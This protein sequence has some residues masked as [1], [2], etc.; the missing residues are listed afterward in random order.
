[1]GDEPQPPVQIFKPLPG[2]KPPGPLTLGE[3]AVENWKLFK[4]KW[5]IYET[6]IKLSTYDRE[7]QVASL[8]NSLGDEALRAYN[9]FDFDTQENVRT[10]AEITAKFDTFI[11]GDVNETYER[12]KFNSTIQREGET[13]ETF[14]SN[15]RC[16]IKTCNYCA[17]C[18]PSILRDRIVLGI[19]E[20]ST[21]QMLLR[22]RDLA[23]DKCIDICKITEDAKAQFDAYKPDPE[24]VNAVSRGRKSKSKPKQRTE[25]RDQTKSKQQGQKNKIAECKFCGKTHEMKKSSCPAWG[26][27]CSNCG[28]KNHYAAKCTNRSDKVNAV[29]EISDSE[30]EDWVCTVTDESVTHKPVRCRMIV[31]NL[32]VVFLVDSGASINIIPK[33]WLTDPSR[34]TPPERQLL[35]WNKTPLT[36]IGSYQATVLN[37]KTRATYSVKFTVVSEDFMPLIG[38]ETALKMELIDVNEHNMEMVA[39]VS[40]TEVLFDDKYRVLWEE[41]LGTFEGEVHL[42]VDESVTPVIMPAKRIP[43]SLKEK[44]HEEL[45]RMQELG[46]IAQVDEPTPWVNQIAITQ[47]KSGAIRVCLDPQQLNRALQREHFMLPVLEDTLHEL[48]T[49][50]VFS[51]FDL[52]SGYWHVGLDHESSLLTTFQ[53][54]FGRYRWLRLPFGLSVSSEIFQKKLLENLQ[55]LSGIACIA[56]DIMVH[57]SDNKTHDTALEALMER[58]L[59]KQIRLNKDK[60]EIRM[61]K[62]T[63]LGH[64]ITSEGLSTDPEKVRAITEFPVPQNVQDLRRFLGMCN[65]LAKYLPNLTEETTGLRNLTKKQ[66]PWTW[67][68]VQQKAFVKVKSMICDAPVL[69]YYDQKVDLCVENDA[70]EHGLGSVIIQKGKP[71]A[72]ASRSLSDPETRYAQIEKEMLALVFGLEKFHCYTYGRPVTVITDHK[73]LIAIV[74]KP[75]SKAPARLQSLLLRAQKYDYELIFKPGKD[76]P[77][78]DALSRAPLKEAPALERVEVNNL[79]FCA[80]KADRLDQIRG[81]TQQDG[82]LVQLMDIVSKGWPADKAALPPSVMPYFPYRDELTVQDGIIMRGERVVIPTSMRKEMKLK[83]H[84]GHLGVNSCLRRAR[85][86]IFWPQMSTDIRQYIEAC[87]VCATFSSK[88]PEEDLHLRAAPER[89]WQTVGCDLFSIEGRNYL[90]TVDCYSN[91]FEVDYL[92]DSTTSEVVVT[93]LKHHFARHGIPDKFISDGGPQFSSE[94]F[95]RFANQWGFV[96]D[97]SSPGNS[98][99]NGSAEAA[100]KNA[101]NIMRKC[102]ASNEDPYIGLLNA[103]NTPTEGLDTSPV[104]RLFNRRTRTLLPTAKSRLAVPDSQKPLMDKRKQIVAE[105]RRNVGKQLKP[106]TLGEQ[107]RMQPVHTGEKGWKP[108]VVTKQLGSRTYEVTGDGGTKYQRNRQQ[109]RQTKT[110]KTMMSP[111]VEKLVS[112]AV[113]NDNNSVVNSPC[114]GSQNTSVAMEPNNAADQVPLSDKPYV[115][116]GVKTYLFHCAYHQ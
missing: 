84:A 4:Q 68:D 41:K 109:I 102:R 40:T 39:S 12:Y 86:L 22:E 78:A 18:Q 104:Q 42:K 55:G 21:Q 87:D 15:L 25:S 1:M 58:C 80:I 81:A 36:P 79:T 17:N 76:I 88:Q 8:L 19:R 106:L 37:P 85:S 33:K 93:K 53:T 38:M 91:F 69:A 56:D 100:V 97:M 108:A 57:G 59:E 98:K 113:N 70:S 103:R 27:K 49:S 32:S 11:V 105:S 9:G 50:R 115:R 3:S 51:K 77:M 35:M 16:R 14:H 114:K 62:I 23:L 95:K 66:V 92:I 107:V 20:K 7:Y 89:P 44:L 96:H 30:S 72:Y 54:C 28:G 6:L 2:V 110:Q 43:V 5:K 94:R 65:Y 83:V 116:K 29:A 82:T 46:V 99:S 90:V 31:D 73:P 24:S 67:S 63:F 60:M 48:S 71:I 13:F 74:K 64:Q 10:V 75:L 34:L 47:K 61:D 101:K 52:T 111:Q 112:V 26:A 45:N